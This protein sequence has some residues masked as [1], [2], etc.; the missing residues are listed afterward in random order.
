MLALGLALFL[1]LTPSS[2]AQAHEFGAP[3][4]V[5]LAKVVSSIAEYKA[6]RAAFT[7]SVLAVSAEPGCH[8]GAVHANCGLCAG[9]HCFGSAAILAA[10]P[11]IGFVPA[12]DALAFLDQT[13]LMPAKPDEAFRPPRSA[14]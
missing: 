7:T 5:S 13:G 11:G 4:G 1:S 14:P 10:A 3:Q 6:D 9:G 12:P 2:P 8:D